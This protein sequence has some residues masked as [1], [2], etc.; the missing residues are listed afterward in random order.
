MKSANVLSE[1]VDYKQVEHG[2]DSSP[3]KE[4]LDKYQSTYIDCSDLI[5]RRR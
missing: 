3:S 4:E 1:P 2:K 5:E